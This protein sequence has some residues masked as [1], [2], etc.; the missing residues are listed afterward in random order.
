MALTTTPGLVSPPRAMR[1]C[2]WTSL[3][4]SRPD[5]VALAHTPPTCTRTKK[6]RGLDCNRLC[7]D[8]RR[9]DY[10]RLLHIHT[11][12]PNQSLRIDRTGRLHAP[13]RDET[14]ENHWPRTRATIPNTSVAAEPAR[15]YTVMP[16][17]QR[18]SRGTGPQNDSHANR[19][20]YDFTTMPPSTRSAPCIPVRPLLPRP[21]RF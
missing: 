20:L 3:P 12:S 6:L 9:A 17:R 5:I 16:F 11:P 21:P 8:T 10:M 19:R 7:I 4:S 2:S 15:R 13:M 18:S 14:G 1:A